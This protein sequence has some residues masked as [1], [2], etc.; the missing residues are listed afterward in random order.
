MR[1]ARLFAAGTAARRPA[2]RVAAAWSALNWPPARPRPNPQTGGD[3]R[4]MWPAQVRGPRSAVRA[5]CRVRRRGELDLDRHC[6]S[7]LR[8]ALSAQGW[9]IWPVVRAR[10]A[11]KAR[12][13]IAPKTT[14]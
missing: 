12:L 8:A 1:W 5:A 4:G 9:T 11:L 14:L 10:R 2:G 3:E 7:W 6:T 13:R